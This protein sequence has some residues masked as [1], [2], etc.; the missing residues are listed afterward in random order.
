MAALEG[1]VNLPGAGAVKKK[2]VVL[3]GGAVLTL[4]AI[5]YVRKKKAANATATA[6]PAD[7]IDPA[8]GFAYGSSED[9]QALAGQS[10]YVAGTDAGG[11][12]GPVP[13]GTTVAPIATNADWTRAAETHLTDNGLSFAP[14]SSALGKYINAQYLDSAE[15]GIV[16]QAIA[17]VGK[18]PVSGPSGYPPSLKL[19]S[20]ST[21]RLKLA[22]PTGL[23]VA[24]MHKAKHE[25][26]LDWGDVPHATEYQIYKNGLHS[27]TVKTSTATVTHSGYF[28]VSAHADGYFNS[29]QSKPVSVLF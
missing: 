11:G 14:V 19:A 13:S 21:P 28:S 10:A 6:V 16:Y 26:V 9:A 18:P 5:Y 3:A 1:T 7:A 27:Q 24:A 17:A 8:T 20:S 23:R 22:T 15:A 2:T 29:S 4:A 25:A 12:G